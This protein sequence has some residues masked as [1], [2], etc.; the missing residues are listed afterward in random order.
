MQ[1]WII[2]G[3]KVIKPLGQGTFGQTWMVE[4]DGTTYALKLFK[5]EMIRSN[6]DVRRIGR[7]IQALKKVNH[8]NVVKYVSDGS[9]VQGFD[10]YRYLVMEYADGEPLRSFIEK[11]VRLTVAMAQRI[12]LQILE[13]LEAIHDS[14]LLHRD[15]K[16]DNIF[17]TK[18]G[19]VRIL[20]FGLVKLLDASTLTA[21]GV[22]MGTYAYM[23]PE[24]LIDSKN[25]DYRADLYS[26]GAIM[27][28]MVTGRI[29]L[30]IYSLVEAPHKILNEAPPFAS[31]LNVSVPN[32][33]DNIISTLL[34]KQI[35]RRSL[36]IQSLKL[37]MQSFIDRSIPA[38]TADLTLRFLPRLLHNERS[39][40]E[41]YNTD[42]GMDG[43]I[44]AANFFPK[45]R[46]VFDSVRDSGSYTVIDPVVYKLAYSKFSDTQSLA[47]L[48]YVLSQLNKEKP[49]D[50]KG[51]DAC[52]KRA[53]LV[54]DWQIQQYPS[55][56]VAPFH[57]LANVNDPWL[58]VDLKVFNECRKY[59]DEIGDP[60]PLYAGI[61]I[62][63]ESIAD[64]ISPIRLINSYTRIQ[65]DG[66]M[67]M[68]DA[69]LDA[70]NRAHYYAF[71]RVVSMLGDIYKP[72]ILSRVNDF[73]L[74][75]MAFGATSISSGIGF[76]E[77]FNEALLIEQNAG[78]MI[79]PRYYIPQLMTS[80][81][82]NA[83]KDILE[84]AIGK[85]LAC[86]CP[87]CEGS[88]DYRHLMSQHITKGHYLYQKHAQVK[89][90]N[91]MERPE[92]FRW[93]MNKVDEAEKLAK[94]IK[95]ASGSKLIQHEYF[96][97]WR[98]ALK[99]VQDSKEVAIYQSAIR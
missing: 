14:G 98:D 97:C 39:L 76:I 78:F 58:D 9:Y 56:L 31:S 24:Q 84:P 38:S 73:G 69:K 83:L 34:E 29:P 5:N 19:E 55:V 79:K 62:Q 53:R 10:K 23:A 60:R 93:F 26:F 1:E 36:T 51:L 42:N 25:V 92:R 91:E 64:D 8:P 32:K 96:K 54:I 95:K 48:P 75:L 4:K 74:G 21:T 27:F 44:F 13:G 86:N 67:L 30:E 80:Y 7:E 33:L 3:Y 28:H 68:F 65:A 89:I 20:D 50:F 52:Q 94:A 70:F 18:M 43:I 45:Y 16:P 82:E 85:Q 59:M 61:S 63:I 17:I 49:E 87:Y 37:D 15:L 71:A 35:H 72:V 41:E 81:S 90:L 2:D 66:Y 12:G 40:I 77:D 57:Y 46:A 22:P 99:E 6:D 47:N 11:Q 88:T